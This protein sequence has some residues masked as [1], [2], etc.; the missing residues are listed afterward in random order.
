MKTFS[1]F[2]QLGFRPFFLLASL[3]SALYM[4]YWLGFQ[5]G[6]LKITGSFSPMIWHG[7][8][9]I[10]GFSTA[11]IAGFVLTA[12]QNWSGIRGIH[13]KKLQLVV[14]L[15]VLARTLILT[16]PQANIITA[17]IDL[18]F[19]PV[20]GIFL[21]PYFK[22]AELKTERVFFIYFLMIMTGNALVHTEALGITTD[23][24]VKGL[25]LGLH[26]IILVILFLGGRV[27]PFFTESNV[28]KSQPKSFSKLEMLC[29]VSA[30]LFLITQFFIP[31]SIISAFIAFF[32]SIS[33]LFR[34][35]GWYVPRVRKVPILWI[36]H[37]SYLWIVIGFFMSA[38]ASMGL[39]PLSIAIHS[40]TVGGLGAII[41]G[42][43]TRVSLGHTGRRLKPNPVIVFGYLCLSL[44]AINRVIL[45]LFFP[46][47]YYFGIYSSSALWIIAF[48]IF[49]WFY[50]PMLLSPRIDEK[51]D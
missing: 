28:S 48:G 38:F 8:E 39:I 3:M 21:W 34:L 23:T 36:L 50:S 37:L 14:T 6:I 32:A 22:D 40:F 5:M 26:T 13:G 7:H 20:T 51:S 25:T 19:M 27:I 47:L 12:S 29:H 1:S 44:A 10:F 46:K 45:P 42:M 18:S 33:N 4:L 30:W 24:A 41:Y 2:W 35:K 9:M 15:W 43:I 17:L 11:V 49:I 16:I 31:N